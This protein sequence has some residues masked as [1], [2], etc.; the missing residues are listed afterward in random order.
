MAPH[1]I[2]TTHT[3][4]LP[5][6]P[7]V[8][9]LLLAQERGEAVDGVRLERTL[10]E[11]VVA[12]VRRQAEVGL[13]IVGDGELSKPSYATYVRDRL[14][15]FTGEV[16]SE[17]AF[18]ADL[19]DFPDF[20]RTILGAPALQQIARPACTGPVRYR[21]TGPVNRDVTR[22]LAAIEGQPHT[23]A[24]LTAASPG[25]IALFLQNHHYPTEE[26]YLDA[27]TA[28][29]RTE[30]E[31]IHE[32]GLLL[33]IDAPDLAMG[34]HLVFAGDDP[35]TFRARVWRR[36]E[37]INRA[38]EA[39]PPERMRLHV[40]WGN[41]AGPHH[42]DV[43]LR[44]ILDLI[45]RARPAGL[46][47]VAANPRHAHEWRV[48]R[49]VRLPEGKYL[50]PGVVDPTTPFIEHPQLVADRLV[51]FADLV[52]PDRVVAGT[53]C[54]FGTFAGMGLDP[55]LAWAKLKALSEGAALATRRLP[56]PGDDQD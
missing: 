8:L 27:L 32:A 5:R 50:I 20:A 6:P 26:A 55:P 18:P 31:A 46:S 36:I 40:C 42:R 33:Q 14:T 54:G 49:E 3:G 52:G 4:S 15:G 51:R 56:H 2:L 37:A 10:R 28:A 12:V 13:D 29:M 7:R 41:Y 22:L 43:A 23:D 53:D 47:F 19:A 21:D 30:Y 44:D 34:R 17:L 9:E 25:V 1:R 11:A 24:F 39:I 35:E 16:V 38:T 45:L 48:F